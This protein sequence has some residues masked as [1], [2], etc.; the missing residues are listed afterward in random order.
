L[1]DDKIII[2]KQSIISKTKI[3]DTPTNRT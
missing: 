2:N 3:N 1:P